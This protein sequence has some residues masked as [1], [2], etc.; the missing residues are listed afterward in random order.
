MCGVKRSET[1]ERF[2]LTLLLSALSMSYSA[3]CAASA[4]EIVFQYVPE[5]YRSQAAGYWASEDTGRLIL[6]S[7]GTYRLERDEWKAAYEEEKSAAEDLATWVTD[8][9]DKLSAA[10]DDERSAWTAR[11]VEL[12]RQARKRWAIG[13]FGGYDLFRREAVCGVGVTYCIFKF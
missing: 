2:L 3:S 5:G 12:E 7:L 1:W 4:Q 10:R 11:T 9:I 6:R 8:R 13:L